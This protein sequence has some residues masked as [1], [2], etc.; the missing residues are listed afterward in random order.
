MK[1]FLIVVLMLGVL[2]MGSAFATKTITITAWTIGPDI[3]SVN[4]FNNLTAAA[5]R[6]NLMLEAV[7]SDIRVKVDGFFDTVSWD[8]Y[9]KKVVFG[10]QSGQPVDILT[11]GNDMIA[12]WAQAGYIIP[13]DKYVN[14]YWESTYS[15]IIPSL[16]EAMK[17]DGKI[18]G[19]PQDTE[20]RP[21]YV[22][23]IAL[24]KLGWTE[25]QIDALPQEV[26]DGQ[27]TL[28]DLIKLGEEAQSKG[29]VKWGFYHR[30]LVGVDFY[31]LLNDYGV[32]F[33]DP[34]QQKFIFSKSGME[35]VLT[36]FYN[37]TNVWKVTPKTLIGTPWNTFYK[38]VVSG[39][40]FADMGGTWDWATWEQTWNKPNEELENMFLP[41]P[42]PA[43]EK[44][45][46]PV[47]LSHPMAYMI[48]KTSQHPAIAA[49]LIALATAP[50]LNFK[51]DL[52]SGHLPIEY[53]EMGYPEYTTNYIIVQGTRMLPF[54][55]FVPNSPQLSYTT[56]YTGILFDAITA[57]E[58]G[59]SVISAEDQM[60]ARLQALYPGLVI[61][62]K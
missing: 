3:P 13:L 17:Y 27:F 29:Y 18:Y 25:S 52:A 51:H 47:T 45:G 4:R 19:I 28:S 20:A 56:Q 49:L 48:A 46:K 39:N 22:N 40:V 24:Q 38:D 60:L 30:P 31:E 11:A 54:T 2:V 9:F 21:V 12:S 50:D 14:D 1:K 35:K 59:Q 37:L 42:L 32:K 33:Y 16:W 61:V 53:T 7:G 15:A 62:E 8:D 41:I 34:Q 6:L 10:L 58:S 36:F 5:S 23:K 26:Y 43:V 57:V 55:S 44:G